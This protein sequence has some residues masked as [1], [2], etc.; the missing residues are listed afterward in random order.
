M[1]IANQPAQLLHFS[2]PAF[3]TTR[4]IRDVSA[5]MAAIHRYCPG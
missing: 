4:L 1:T 3:I 2:C 5:D